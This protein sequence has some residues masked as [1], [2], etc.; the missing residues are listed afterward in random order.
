MAERSTLTETETRFVHAQRV[1]RMATAD[2]EGHPYAIPVCYAFD[3]THFYTPLDQKPKSV[4]GRQLRR[5]RN[6]E[7][8][9]EAALLIDQYSDDWTQ[10][11]YVLIHGHAE[12]IDPADSR[13]A[14]AIALLRTRYTQYL[15]MTLEELPVIVITPVKVVSW[16]PAIG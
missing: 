14:P 4:P 12:L 1:A 9:H 16:G 11:G 13:H 2:E 8:N 15:T 7:A 6:I 5:V 3:G 10:L